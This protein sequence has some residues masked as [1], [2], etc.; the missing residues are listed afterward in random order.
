M[1][2][3]FSTSEPESGLI[4]R[5]T[6]DQSSYLRAQNNVVSFRVVFGVEEDIPAAQFRDNT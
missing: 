3:T 4:A 6:I 1:A 5:F 2:F